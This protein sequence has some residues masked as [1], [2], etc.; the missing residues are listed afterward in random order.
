MTGPNLVNVDADLV[1]LC[2]LF[3]PQAL[4]DRMHEP[5]HLEQAQGSRYHTIF[6]L[7]VEQSLPNGG[8]TRGKIM[9]ADLAGLVTDR[10]LMSREDSVWIRDAQPTDDS[11]NA[12][13][14]V[15]VALCKNEEAKKLI[16]EN[17]PARLVKVPWQNCKLTMLLHV[18]LQRNFKVGCVPSLVLVQSSEDCLLVLLRVCDVESPGPCLKAIPLMCPVLV[19]CCTMCGGSLS[20]L[21]C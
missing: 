15:L 17:K 9:F 14:D 20:H 13:R 16:Q 12:V 18:A 5:H 7:Y 10:D 8:V 3:G 11:L 1:L 21:S 6:L 2:V 19:E 4:L